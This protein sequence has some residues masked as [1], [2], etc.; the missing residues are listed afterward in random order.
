MLHNEFSNAAS[1]LTTVVLAY[2]R[3][4]PAFHV[5]PFFSSG[6]ISASVRIPV[7][8]IVSLAI[9][10]YE[11]TNYATL[12]FIFFLFIALREIIIGLL[13]AYI[14]SLPFWVYHAIGSF[15]DNQRG[16]TLSS[17]LDPS[18]GVDSSELAKF[19]N[20]F[21]AVVYLEN[22]GLVHLLT[23]FH[24][25][26][27][28]F[29]PFEKNL[30]NFLPL[31]KFITNLLVNTIIISSPVI[32]MLLLSEIFLGVL[33]RYASQLNAFSVSLTIKSGIAFA[34]LILYFYP[35]FIERVMR[36]TPSLTDISNFL[37]G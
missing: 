14:L 30:P 34:I 3:I 9:V 19:L 26:Y 6:N 4:G 18:S 15:I 17:T 36:I 24:N 31:T 23:V 25:S 35:T 11:A 21:A 37:I 8:G 2:C 20:M 12:S 29:S 13:L 28:L 1:F 22:N 7:I 5:L 16:A 10:P 27:E 33:S 32:A